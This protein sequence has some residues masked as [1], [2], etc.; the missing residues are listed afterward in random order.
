MAATFSSISLFLTSAAFYNLAGMQS[1]IIHW[2]FPEF[3]NCKF[4]KWNHKRQPSLFTK[5]CTGVLITSSAESVIVFCS[6]FKG[7]FRCS[8][9]YGIW[10]FTTWFLLVIHNISF[11]LRRNQVSSNLLLIFM[12]E[13]QRLSRM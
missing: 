12:E 7:S 1:W 4:G 10:Y 2:G 8:S 13:F 5:C 6:L 9:F 3:W 11:L